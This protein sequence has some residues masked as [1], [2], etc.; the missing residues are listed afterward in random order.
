MSGGQIVALIFAILL[1]LPGA[2]FLWVGVHGQ[3]RGD[4]SPSAPP[5]IFCVC[6]SGTSRAAVLDRFQAAVA[7]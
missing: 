3:F 6:Y 1:L 4:T 7:H 5:L 2:C